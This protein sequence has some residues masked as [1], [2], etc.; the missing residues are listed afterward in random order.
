MGWRRACG[1]LHGVRGWVP[2]TRKLCCCCAVLLLMS[3]SRRGRS[4]AGR[5]VAHS[6]TETRTVI[7]RGGPALTVRGS[8]GVVGAA[9]SACSEPIWRTVRGL[10]RA[11]PT[12]GRC[13]VGCAARPL[14][15]GAVTSAGRGAGLGREWPVRAAG[16]CGRWLRSRRRSGAGEGPGEAPVRAGGRLNGRRSVRGSTSAR[17]RACPG[18]GGRRARGR[19][20]PGPVPVVSRAAPERTAPSTGRW[21]KGVGEVPATV[22]GR[23]AGVPVVGGR[24]AVPRPSRVGARPPAGPRSGGPGV[25][26]L[27]GASLRMQVRRALHTRLPSSSVMTIS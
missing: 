10:P 26:Q 18:G 23:S 15:Y 25:C 20:S 3:R 4:R 19:V 11:T 17:R 5:S 13:E 21:P 24:G 16:R 8:R 12:S 2:S 1:S 6:Y 27:W 14:R 22:R 9:N 7:G